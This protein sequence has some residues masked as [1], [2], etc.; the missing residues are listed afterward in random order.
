MRSSITSAH[1][2]VEDGGDE[3]IDFKMKADHNWSPNTRLQGCAGFLVAN[4]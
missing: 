3:E 4:M 1:K 2:G